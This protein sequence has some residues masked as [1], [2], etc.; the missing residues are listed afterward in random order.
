MD[1]TAGRQDAAAA[2]RALR[3]LGT[4]EE[5]AHR[6]RAERMFTEAGNSFSPWLL[7]RTTWHW[8]RIGI[9]GMLAFFLAL[10]GYSTALGFTFT[11]LAKISRSPHVGVWWGHDD[12]VIGSPASTEGMHEL[13]GQWFAPVMVMAAFGLAA[14]TTQALRWLIRRRNSHPGNNPLP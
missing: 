14:G 5:L 8:A 13:L 10:V 6:Y 7:L 11:I 12:L 3:L 1:S 4:P 9:E 2:E